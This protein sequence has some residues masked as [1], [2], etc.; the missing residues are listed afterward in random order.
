VIR[1]RD[2]ENLSARLQALLRLY[3]EVSEVYG[4][5]DEATQERFRNDLRLL[6]SDYGASAVEAALDDILGDSSPPIASP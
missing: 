1:L 2:G 3:A 4:W 6:V 5:E